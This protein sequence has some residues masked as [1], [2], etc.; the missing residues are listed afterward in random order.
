MTNTLQ[1][2]TSYKSIGP[3]TAWMFGLGT[4]HDFFAQP[5]HAGPWLMSGV[6]ERDSGGVRALGAANPA[7]QIVPLWAGL[8]SPR[9]LPFILGTASQG[10]FV[11]D[12]T[13][14]ALNDWATD[15]SDQTDEVSFGLPVV[16]TTMHG[17][18]TQSPRGHLKVEAV[19]PSEPIVVVGI[20]DD[21]IG[22][23]HHAF[24]DPD[25]TSR[26]DAVW[27]QGVAGE[28]AGAV[29]FGRE[30]RQA[31][32]ADLRRDFGPDEDSIYRAV[33]LAPGQK[34]EAGALFSGLAHGTHVLDT[35]VGDIPDA[36]VRVVAVDLPAVTTWDTSGHGKDMFMLAALHF[37]FDR[38]DQ[39]AQAYGRDHVP[40][41]VNMSYG[42]CG[43]AH[44]GSATV[45]AAF[46]ELVEARREFAPTAL[47]LP[48]GNNFLDAMHARSVLHPRQA[49]DPMPWR[50][51][52]DDRSSN[53]LEI[54]L[55]P[56][57]GPEDVKVT[58][59]SPARVR[60]DVGAEVAM[61]GG[62]TVTGCLCLP[63]VIDAQVVG[64][65]SIDR[66]RDDVWRVLIALAPTET[67]GASA[68][69][70]QWHVG[71]DDLRPQGEPISLNMWIQRDISYGTST[72]GAR[73]SYFDEFENTRL[74]RRGH[75]AATDQENVKT[76]RFGSLSGL[77][78]GRS[79]LVISAA[80]REPLRPADYSAA[81]W[82]TETGEGVDVAAIV[83]TSVMQRG[84]HGAGARSGASVSMSGTSAAAPLA[85]RCLID[86]FR[87]CSQEV[88]RDAAA[89]N[90]LSLLPVSATS[91]Q[92]VRV[93]AGVL[94]GMPRRA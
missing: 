38:A 5:R 27:V 4:E 65:M 71:F 63:V 36:Q 7:P 17:E 29:P 94:E 42:Y 13:C 58:L 87:S 22:F 80:Q 23:A 60:G 59:Y 57:M 47:V 81:G 70:G 88:L 61:I 30:L 32:I 24:D 51:Q 49:S 85:T 34:T 20:I 90:Y 55:P 1:S 78:T 16:A 56:E 39:I 76:K 52:P 28:E 44:R 83:E 26:I 9:F 40:V 73:Q 79:S 67:I 54:W 25:G 10:P 77:A 62:A 8:P 11:A 72:S 21:G 15:L 6:L 84:V 18:R 86:A 91:L 53:F 89:S 31:D 93:G 66:P 46:D 3:Y 12:W 48:S 2:A 41:I 19:D 68:P 64:Q 37:I 92:S 82:E 50:L 14:G 74:D 43:G 33:G 75:W 69:C 45:E 35:A